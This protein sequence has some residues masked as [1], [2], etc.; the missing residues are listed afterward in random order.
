MA[1]EHRNS[2]VIDWSDED[3]VYVVSLPEW[4]DLVHTHGATHEEALQRGKELL[5]ALIA[6][7]KERGERL[8]RPHVYVAR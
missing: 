4:G 7:R 8:P 6:P 5:D 1:H 3:G 2:I